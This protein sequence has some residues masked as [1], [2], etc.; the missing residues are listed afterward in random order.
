MTEIWSPPDR[1]RRTSPT[2]P[3]CVQ[4]VQQIGE[5]HGFLVDENMAARILWNH[6]G[7]PH[8]W[9]GDPVDCLIRSVSEF[10]TEAKG[11]PEVTFRC[12]T[13]QS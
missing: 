1:W 13:L 4:L 11:G 7:F 10:F 5:A 8:F 6:T 9:D 3:T 12:E 2:P